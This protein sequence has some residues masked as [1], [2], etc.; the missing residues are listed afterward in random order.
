LSDEEPSADQPRGFLES[1]SV[2]D[3]SPVASR[4]VGIIQARGPLPPVRLEPVMFWPYFEIDYHIRLFLK[5]PT[6]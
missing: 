2:S 1:R 3:V 6:S 5:P 4:S